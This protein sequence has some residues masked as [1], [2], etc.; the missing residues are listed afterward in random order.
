MAIP[1]CG[2]APPSSDQTAARR[3]RGS[4]AQR[5][6][7]LPPRA[8]PSPVILDTRL[9]ISRNTGWHAR[10]AFLSGAK[11]PRRRS[12]RSHSSVWP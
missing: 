12:A 11:G 4:S 6:P 10:G 8:P 3:R 1:R 9:A 5:T 2:P 7:A